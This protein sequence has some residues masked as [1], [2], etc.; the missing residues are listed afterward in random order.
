VPAAGGKPEQL[1]KVAEKETAHRW[2]SIVPNGRAVLF[3]AWRETAE[4]SRLAVVSLDTREVSYLTPG[5]SHPQYVSTGHI[6]YAAGGGLRA[7]GFDPARL[8]LTGD[9]P[10]PV[11]D[12]V[13]IQATG[14]AQFDVSANGSLVY[15][16]GLSPA[17]LRTLVWIDREGREEPSGFEPR[18]Y[19]GVDISPDGNRIGATIVERGTAETWISSASSPGWSKLLGSANASGFGK[20]VWRMDSRRSACD[21]SR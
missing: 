20:L 13:Q 10:T 2:P 5:G 17:A 15:V 7:V 19:V 9:A 18:G 11:V 6:V 3:T 14:A 16:P 21:L 4:N 12:S 8:A 1:T